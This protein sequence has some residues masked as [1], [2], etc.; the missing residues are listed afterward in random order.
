MLVNTTKTYLTKPTYPHPTAG[1]KNVITSISSATSGSTGNGSPAITDSIVAEI[2]A[3]IGTATCTTATEV[4]I[5][6]EYLN[7]TSTPTYTCFAGVSSFATCGSASSASPIVATFVE[8]ITTLNMD[9]RYSISSNQNASGGPTTTMLNNWTTTFGEAEQS[10]EPSTL[11]LL[12]S[13]LAALAWKYGGEPR[14]P[15]EISRIRYFR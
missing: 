10:P 14:G 7:N 3:C 1:F 8:G 15:P 5:E 11:P 6:S 2:I 12:G 13:A 4:K 9:Y